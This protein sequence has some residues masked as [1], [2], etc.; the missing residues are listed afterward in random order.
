MGLKIDGIAASEH[1][2]SSGEVLDIKNLD[3]SD[4][5][6]GKG[7]LNFEHKSDTP[8]DIIGKIIY[9]KK[10]FSKDD[11]E[12]AR[13]EKYWNFCKTPFLYI[14]AELFDDEEHPGAVAAAAIIRYYDKHKQSVLV[15][16]SVEGTTLE[17]NGNKLIKTIGRRV[18][19]TL[20][21]CNKSCIAAI[22]EDNKISDK[23]KKH[24][25]MENTISDNVYQIDSI[26]LEDNNSQNY[27]IDYI[28]NLLISFQK[29]LDA[30]NTNV[31]PSALS[32][33][34]AL[35]KE[36]ITPYDLN[37]ILVNIK[38]ILSKWDTKRPLREVLSEALPDI[39]ARYLD[40]FVEIINKI[41]MQKTEPNLNNEILNDLSVLPIQ[42]LRQKDLSQELI[43]YIVEAFHEKNNIVPNKTYQFMNYI[44][45]HIDHNNIYNMF[46]NTLYNYLLAEWL[47]VKNFIISDNII[48]I[49][50]NLWYVS[51][52]PADSSLFLNTHIPSKLKLLNNNAEFYKL[53]LLDIILNLWS[54]RNGFNVIV[55]DHN[56]YHIDNNNFVDHNHIIDMRLA[57][58]Y[59]SYI[60]EKYISE[61][62]NLD[63]FSSVNLYNILMLY[64]PHIPALS[65]QIPI[66]I[67][68]FN[69]IK[70][71]YKDHN[72]NTMLIRVKYAI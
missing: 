19:L 13:Q 63:E 17:R 69:T 11:C 61:F 24:F 9:A 47:C 58:I 57:N 38:N 56:I 6:E 2:D 21:P 42:S 39:D 1:I 22:L 43:S 32:N 50:K 23:I 30:G 46:F 67:K 49:Y 25:F 37:D 4:F 5:L 15:G 26:I 48:N 62:L 51:K 64:A 44:I 36:H 8:I 20:T 35:Q 71:L 70:L 31:A 12:N 16:Y 3:I 60:H 40:Y 59:Y 7:V 27:N 54:F 14:I 55:D 53:L 18:A 34:P 65:H 72:I 68:R 52:L 41:K 45:T 33:G 10:I 66:I 28:K 29:T